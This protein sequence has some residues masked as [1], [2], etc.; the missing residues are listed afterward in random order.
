MTKTTQRGLVVKR[1][2]FPIYPILGY[3][4]LPVFISLNAVSFK[5]ASKSFLIG[6]Q[7]PTF[8]GDPA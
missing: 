5:I 4:W 1:L 7:L 6:L 3:Q 8:G 2:M